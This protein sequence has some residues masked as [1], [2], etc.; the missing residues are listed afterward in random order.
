MLRFQLRVPTRRLQIPCRRQW[1][2]VHRF[3]DALYDILTPLTT[4]HDF[5]PPTNESLFVCQHSAVSRT[6]EIYD[7]YVYLRPQT[8]TTPRP[9][10]DDRATPARDEGDRT[11]PARDGGDRTRPARDGGSRPTS[12]VPT[13]DAVWKSKRNG[14][15]ESTETQA[16]PIGACKYQRV[17]FFNLYVS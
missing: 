16:L 12:R 2:C 9:R 11:R 8:R 14:A 15:C 6:S 17:Y 3:T 7:C 4:S 5:S 1:V 10:R 13:L